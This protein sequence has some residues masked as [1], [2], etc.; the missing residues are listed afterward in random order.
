MNQAQRHFLDDDVDTLTIYV[1]GQAVAKTP[2]DDVY[3]TTPP[4]CDDKIAITATISL[5]IVKQ[6]HSFQLRSNRV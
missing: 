1:N 3:W 5:N 6:K 2:V 4:S